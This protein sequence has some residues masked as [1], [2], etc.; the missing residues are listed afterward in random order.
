MPEPYSIEGTISEDGKILSGNNFSVKHIST[1]VYVVKFEHPFS[2]QTPQITIDVSGLTQGATAKVID[3]T[4]NSFKYFTIQM[5]PEDM[6]LVDFEINFLAEGM[7][8]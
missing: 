2:Y 5:D 1:G 7:K 3:K 4:L 6:Y 8:M